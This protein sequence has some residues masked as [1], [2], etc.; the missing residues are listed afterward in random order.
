MPHS[1]S[2]RLRRR[3]GAGCSGQMRTGSARRREACGARSR[4]TGARLRCRAGESVLPGRVRPLLRRPG[5]DVWRAGSAGLRRAVAT[6]SRA[7]TEVGEKPAPCSG[8]VYGRPGARDLGSDAATLVLL[9]LRAPA[10][11]RSLQPELTRLARRLC[12]I[13]RRGDHARRAGG[14]DLAGNRP[15]QPAA[16]VAVVHGDDLAAQP[17]VRRAGAGAD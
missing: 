17:G 8:S 6:T 7:S 10:R 5:G 9:G 3:P 1:S 14:V 16:V 12:E 15:P 2:R 4:A 11:V 13:G